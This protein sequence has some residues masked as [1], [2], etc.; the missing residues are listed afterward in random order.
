MTSAHAI[1]FDVRPSPTLILL[2]VV[3]V[4]LATAAPLFAGLPWSCRLSLALVIAGVGAWRLRAFHRPAVAALGWSA[5]DVWHVT[6]A[7]GSGTTAELRDSRI[8]AGAVFLHL[9]WSGGA[10]HVA[11]LA[12]NAPA[13]ELRRLRARLHTARSVGTPATKVADS[14]ARREGA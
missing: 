9:R 11:L 13:D 7:D 4:V 3:V 14:R 1:S 10:V 12:D 6:L 8:V 2:A 5:A